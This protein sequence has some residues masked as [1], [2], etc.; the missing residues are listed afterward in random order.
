[1][2][3]R[4]QR[5]RLQVQ[6][7][8]L[9]CRCGGRQGDTARALVAD[10]LSSL[11]VKNQLGQLRLAGC[12][13]KRAI[14]RKALSYAVIW[15]VRAARLARQ[16]HGTRQPRARPPAP[17]A[18]SP[19]LVG[20][21]RRRARRAPTHGPGRE[22]GALPAAAGLLRVPPSASCGPPSAPLPPHPTQT[23]AAAQR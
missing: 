17:A 21:Q 9:V 7:R 12:G 2:L 10:Q 22:G 11:P 18:A 5:W 6:R 13:G 1:M 23:A 19:H 15:E 20:R 8:L 4:L 3:Q 14:G 16:P